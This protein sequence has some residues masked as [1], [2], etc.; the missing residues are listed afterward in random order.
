MDITN[1]VENVHKIQK[2]ESNC[3]F[4]SKIKIYNDN[5]EENKGYVYSGVSKK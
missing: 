1:H 5:F 2:T 4:L 3:I